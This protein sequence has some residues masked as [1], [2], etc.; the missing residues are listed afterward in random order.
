MTSTSAEARVIVMQKLF[1]FKIGDFE[2]RLENTRV[3]AEFN[4][5][6]QFGLGGGFERFG[7]EV[8]A[9]SD[10]LSGSIGYELLRVQSV[11]QG[12]TVT[13][14]CQ[15]APQMT[16][17]QDPQG[18]EQQGP[19]APSTRWR[20]PGY[21]EVDPEQNRA[22]RSVRRRQPWH[23]RPGRSARRIGGNTVQRKKWC[24]R[25]LRP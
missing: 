21:P 12:S 6:K 15:W 17:A 3:L 20:L 22:Q 1:G 13:S 25:R 7:F 5:T 16:D 14:D 9:E 10:G 19:G 11:F 2:G 4:V 23:P 8:D 24:S 18:D